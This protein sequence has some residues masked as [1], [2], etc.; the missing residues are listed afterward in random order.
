MSQINTFAV[1]GMYAV[2]DS[3]TSTIGLAGVAGVATIAVTL[4][5]RPGWRQQAI[6][7]TLFVTAAGMYVGIGYQRIGFGV[8]GGN[9][10]RYQHIGAMLLA[11]GFAVAV[12]RLRQLAPEALW[13]GRLVLVAAIGVNGGAL[14]SN[15]S[16]WA[17][18]S[19][20]ERH[21]L[22]LIAG[23]PLSA[24]VDPNLRPLPFSPDVSIASLPA[25]IADGAFEP[26][27]PST[28]D[29]EALVRSALG[30]PP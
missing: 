20:D 16:A 22:E 30:L 18:R 13:A 7:I 1:H 26:L 11:P 21:V 14:H 9:I 19:T 24:T 17:T 23:S 6:L 27:V 2:F 29:E 25:L 3:L 12:D 15:S 10:S 8:E 4:W 5:R 28:P